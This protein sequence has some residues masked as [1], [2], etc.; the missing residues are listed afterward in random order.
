MER[1]LDQ[2]ITFHRNN[3]L[4]EGV[5]IDIDK[6]GNAVLDINSIRTTISSGALEL[7]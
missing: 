5:F 2:S 1:T 7:S 4:I 6:N 3:D